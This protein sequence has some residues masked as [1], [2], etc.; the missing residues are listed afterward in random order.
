MKENRKYTPLQMA[1]SF[2]SRCINDAE[3][4]KT[5]LP[6][7]PIQHLETLVNFAKDAERKLASRTVNGTINPLPFQSTE[8]LDD[9]EALMARYETPWKEIPRDETTS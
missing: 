8:W 7:I 9:R 6:T 2:G 4:E 5:T 1:V 3:K